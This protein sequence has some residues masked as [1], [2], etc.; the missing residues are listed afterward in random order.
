MIAAAQGAIEAEAAR[1]G[2]YEWPARSCVSLVEELSRRACGIVPD[3]SEARALGEARCAALARTRY[4]SFAAAHGAILERTGAW[5]RVGGPRPFPGHVVALAGDVLGRDG[6]RYRP[7]L[8]SLQ[9]L[10]VVGPEGAPWWWSPH[11]L[12]Y[13]VSWNGVAEQWACRPA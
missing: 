7:S 5:V 8:P 9:L 1:P 13:A 4:G 2:G 12:T 3:Y 10:A 6:S 11:G